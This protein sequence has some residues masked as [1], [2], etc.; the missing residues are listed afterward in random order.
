MALRTPHWKLLH[1]YQAEGGWILGLCPD[2]NYDEEWLNLCR[3]GYLEE[4]AH[5]SKSG[6]ELT[7]KALQALEELRVHSAAS[8]EPKHLGEKR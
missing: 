6:H 8:K 4:R 2:P 7:E 3:D 1:Q 5:R